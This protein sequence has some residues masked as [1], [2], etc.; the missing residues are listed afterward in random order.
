MEEKVADAAS[1]LLL[2]ERPISGAMRLSQARSA[3]CSAPLLRP[4]R[5]LP[6]ASN[7]FGLFWLLQRG[8][9]A[10]G[11]RTIMSVPL[12]SH[13]VPPN[14]AAP[15]LNC[16]G[17]FINARTGEQGAIRLCSG[18]SDNAPQAWAAQAATASCARPPAR[19][20]AQSRALRPARPAPPTPPHH[21]PGRIVRQIL[22]HIRPTSIAYIR[23]TSGLHPAHHYLYRSA[24]STWATGGR[25]CTLSGRAWSPP[26]GASSSPERRDSKKIRSVL[27]S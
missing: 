17:R 27:R 7:R 14:F 12:C 9:A 3:L 6:A 2:T 18:S 20:S 11:C 19:L 4:L 26:E 5:P 24:C 8:S 15:N 10:Q 1:K 23:P 25:N 13:A 22:P 16:R 21:C